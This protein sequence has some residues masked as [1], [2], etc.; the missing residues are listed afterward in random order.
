MNLREAQRENVA[1]K[2]Y[3][4]FVR[5]SFTI[6]LADPG[7]APYHFVCPKT[8]NVLNFVYARNIFRLILL[9]KGPIHA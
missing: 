6:P 5:C 8:V 4:P 7:G 2:T 9:E 1:N 3:C